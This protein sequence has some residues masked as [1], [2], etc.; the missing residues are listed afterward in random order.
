M[1][2]SL[3]LLILALSVCMSAQ[4][5]APAPPRQGSPQ[6]GSRGPGQRGG[7]GF[8][9]TTGTISEI[10]DNVLTIKTSDGKTLNVKTSSDTRFLG[11]DRTPIAIKD[12]KVG[13]YIA[14]GGQPSGEGA[15]EAR[16]VALLDEET[17]KRMKEAQTNLGKTN[18]AGEVKE[19][20]ETKLT[21]LRIDGQSQV[22]EVDENTSL[23][24]QGES[25]TLADIKVGDRLSG[26]G[27]LKNGVFTAKELRVGMPGGGLRR[28]QGGMVAPERS[29]P[30][31]P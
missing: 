24:K 19:I 27:E 16:M 17:V 13:D 11:K 9:G 2:A 1:K 14:T 18:I 6:G 23:K 29:K 4:D 5:P 8:G 10:K 12:L 30:E 26:P 25:I 21:I 3:V 7:F 20:N 28:Q 15:I 22:I 31:K